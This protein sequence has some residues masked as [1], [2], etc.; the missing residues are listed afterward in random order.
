MNEDSRSAQNGK[1]RRLQG[2]CDGCRKKKVKCDSAEMPGNR[3]TNCITLTV[4]CTHDRVNLKETPPTPPRRFKTAQE[5]VADI[6]STST[7]Y[8]P[9]NDPYTSHRILV[10]L[11]QYAR[12]L[13]ERLAS[14]HRQTHVPTTTTSNAG[15]PAAFAYDSD[16]S[17]NSFAA[18]E[19]FPIK[20]PLTDLI[21]TPTL[22]KPDRFFGRS[23]SVQ[24]T[25]AAMKQM[26]GNT[27]YVFGVQRPE[28]WIAQ[29]WERL[30]IEPPQ[31]FFPENDL[32]KCL[33][34]IYFDQINP[35]IGILHYP[36]FHQSLSSGLHFR[37]P[38]F[39]AVVLAVCSL[40]SRYSDDPR[41]FLDGANSE[42]S[43]GWKWFRQ[44]RPIRASFSP[45]PSLQQ[46]Q[47]VFLS[48]L[49]L[50]GSSSPEESFVLAGLGIRF[51]QGAGAHHRAGYSHMQPL[52]A[53]LYRRVFW[54][55]V[56]TDTLISS[57]KGRPKIMDSIDI[58]IDFP[59]GCDE[60]HW[61][62]PNARQPHGIPSNSAFIVVYLK[63]IMIFGRIQRVVY[64]VNGLPSSQDAVAKLDSDLNGWVDS[65]PNHLR[66]DPHQPNQVFLDQ[67]ALLYT[68]YYH[69]QILIHR[70]FIPTPGKSSVSN[71]S[72]PSL[73]I[74]ANAARS[75]GHVLDVQTRRGR[76][77]LP[78]P[79]VMTALF[80][81]AVVLLI[82]VWAVVGGRKS[83][84]PE[85]FNRATADVQHCVRVLR[86]YERRWRGAGRKGDI[87]AA[88]LTIGKY[89]S[90]SF[91][92]KRPRDV[93]EE[94]QSS[95]SISDVHLSSIGE[96]PIAGSSRAAS[97]VQQI[98]ALELSM[99]EPDPVF[100]L[101]LHTEEL[102]RLPIYDSFDY[103]FSI[104]SD[105]IQ[106]QPQSHLHNQSPDNRKQLLY[107]VDPS[108]ESM[109]AT[110]I[111]TPVGFSPDSGVEQLQNLLT[112]PLSMPS[113][114]SWQEWS[115]YLASVEGL[116]TETLYNSRFV[117]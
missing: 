88:L 68:T 78:H 31:H 90:A 51:A 3:C 37:D 29:P 14:L 69:A 57:F 112:N 28:F 106:Y 116:N 58:D 39:G 110:A 21:P 109:F 6:L 11:A 25:K 70:P 71:I 13:E 16:T 72:F 45:E 30:I 100:S 73:A 49:Y 59:A 23:S 114:N 65:V 55:L 95:P 67:S 9:S 62:T 77:I 99:Q 52:E 63:L 40:A 64:P 47:L 15:S 75:C 10:E 38:H 74:C 113:G 87:I 34:K 18:L 26:H 66:W 108:I 24:F 103:D 12:A 27:E 22:Q 50:A 1:K 5:H 41:V 89:T 98:Q 91:A 86:L 44:V 101:P 97:M 8:I 111:P 48:V 80:D 82:N 35:L 83:R 84:T 81:C 76:G 2:A 17:E 19:E 33:L 32:L 60:Q 61:G 4:D 92:L 107:G 115:T 94:L 56:A 7:V 53:E 20:D 79:H 36:S 54:I 46:L 117:N 42:H 85:D 102:G 96:R 93:E 105:N 43:C 104:P